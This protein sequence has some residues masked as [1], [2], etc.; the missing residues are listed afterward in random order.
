MADR[1]A[2]NR[3]VGQVDRIPP[4]W[5]CRHKTPGAA[6]CT[7]FPGG[8]PADILDGRNQHREPYPGD[9]GIRYERDPG[10]ARSG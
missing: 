7:A 4:C 10:V 9:N 8:I 6:T 3:F 2:N 1:E 5:T